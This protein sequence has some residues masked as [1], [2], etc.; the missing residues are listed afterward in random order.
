MPNNPQ[1]NASREEL[2]AILKAIT[3]AEEIRFARI[4]TGRDSGD[5]FWNVTMV[6]EAK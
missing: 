5:G 4:Y 2:I 3:E 6:V 1:D